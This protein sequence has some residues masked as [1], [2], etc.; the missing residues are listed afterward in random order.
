L[1]AVPRAPVA[2]DPAAGRATETQPSAKKMK[3]KKRMRMKMKKWNPQREDWE[4]ALI[5][6]RV[7]E[8]TFEEEQH[9]RLVLGAKDSARVLGSDR[10]PLVIVERAEW[11]RI[12]LSP[13]FSVVVEE[14]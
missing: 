2:G 3:K 5:G 7:F 10:P 12:V 13:T 1:R 9:V 4:E 11:R 6:E 8:E 14:V